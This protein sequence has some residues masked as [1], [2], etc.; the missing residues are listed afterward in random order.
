ME[1][2]LSLFET[3]NF[4][5][6]NRDDA[7]ILSSHI[8]GESV[9][10]TTIKNIND[11]VLLDA[12]PWFLPYLIASEYNDKLPLSEGT[13]KYLKLNPVIPD[14]CDFKSL[15]D[16]SNVSKSDNNEIA[17]ESVDVS[18]S[19]PEKINED[20][21]PECPVAPSPIM[22]NETPPETVDSP[23]SDPMKIMEPEPGIPTVKDVKHH[24]PIEVFEFNHSNGSDNA[25]TS[26]RRRRRADDVQKPR[27]AMKSVKFLSTAKEI[28]IEN[29]VK[30]FTT[31]M[32]FTMKD[33]SSIEAYYTSTVIPYIK[34]CF[35]PQN[36]S[37]ISEI[38]S[39][40]DGKILR[41]VSIEMIRAVLRASEKK[42][43][44]SVVRSLVNDALKKTSSATL[45]DFIAQNFPNFPTIL[46]DVLSDLKTKIK[47]L[48]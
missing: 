30:S 17:T 29:A 34:S 37:T 8:G 44:A 2:T 4:E 43:S 14:N 33:Q 41:F 15:E 3:K 18:L 39:Y 46:S 19:E 36:V 47:S 9:I 23:K 26:V 38:Y 42:F 24:Q 1:N 22:E 31:I 11:D 35:K 5:K 40:D 32:K 27:K 12:V 16:I 13:K 7:E 21:P 48:K 45:H 6:L 25:T 20:K 28:E 10:I